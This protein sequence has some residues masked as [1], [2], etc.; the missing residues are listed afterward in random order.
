MNQITECSLIQYILAVQVYACLL[1][2]KPPTVQWDLR[3]G[4]CALDTNFNC[5]SE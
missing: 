3:L 1:R 4:K 5:D 2:T